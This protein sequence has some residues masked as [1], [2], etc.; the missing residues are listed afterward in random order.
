MYSTGMIQLFGTTYRI[1]RVRSGC[2]EIIRICDEV[3]AGSFSCGQKLQVVPLAVHA[4]LMWRLAA[5][6]VQRGKT[7]WMGP[8]CIALT[9]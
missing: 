3:L 2:Y 6:A 1:S 8:Q 7:N 4:E 5:V 9:R